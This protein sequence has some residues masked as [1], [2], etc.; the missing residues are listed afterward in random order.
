M[1]QQLKKKE[2]A[3]NKSVNLTSALIIPSAW[4]YVCIKWL[5]WMQ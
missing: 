5:D 4:F 1:I 3:L 2:E